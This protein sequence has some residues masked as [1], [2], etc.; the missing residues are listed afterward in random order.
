MSDAAFTPEI[1][2]DLRTEVVHTL[3]VPLNRRIRDAQ[4]QV[5]E[6]EVTQVTVTRPKGKHLKAASRFKNEEEADMSLIGPLTGLADKEIDE[7][8]AADIMEIGAIIAG[9][10]RPGRRSGATTSEV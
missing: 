6:E 8:D 1:E 5:R 9:F 2:R 10:V 4:G 7:M 3:I